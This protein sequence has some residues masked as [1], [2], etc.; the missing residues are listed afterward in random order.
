MLS[1]AFSPDS[2]YALTGSKDKSARLWDLKT[3]ESIKTLSGHTDSV[4]ST[5]FSPDG[6]YA[7]TGSDD[8]TV[9]LWEFDWELEFMEE[10]KSSKEVSDGTTIKIS[11]KSK[12]VPSSSN[13]LFKKITN[14]F[15]K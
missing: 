3:G 5:A 9:R 13:S 8:G 10:E 4:H 6:R 1:V 14:L 12:P 15:K 11:S 7:L 2:R